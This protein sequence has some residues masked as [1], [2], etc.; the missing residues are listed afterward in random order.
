MNRSIVEQ[1][2]KKAGVNLKGWLPVLECDTCK[3]TWEPFS[4]AS[5]SGAPTARLNYWHCPN[6]CN[7]G[8]QVGREVE[9]AI[10]KYVVINDV[11]GM[12]FGDEDLP[13]FE[14]YVRSKNVTQIP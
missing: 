10:P 12:L 14:K 9:T 5:G 13:E 2:L 1:E 8:R 11:P 4:A 3:E 7:A 6:Q